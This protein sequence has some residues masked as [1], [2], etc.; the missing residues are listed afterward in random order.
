MTNILLYILIGIGVGYF[1]YLFCHKWPKL[2]KEDLTSI[3]FSLKSIQLLPKKIWASVI[4]TKDKLRHFSFKDLLRPLKKIRPSSIGDFFRRLKIK[5]FNQKGRFLKGLA[6]IKSC[7]KALLKETKDAQNFLKVRLGELKVGKRGLKLP[8]I[9]KNA[10]FSKGLGFQRKIQKIKGRTIKIFLEE[11]K[12]KIQVRF[13]SEEDR[14]IKKQLQAPKNTVVRPESYLGELLRKTEEA[15]LSPPAKKGLIEKQKE[16]VLITQ[17]ATRGIPDFLKETKPKRKA[18]SLEIS[19]ASIKKIEDRLMSEILEDP[20]NIEAYKKLGR[21]YYNQFKYHYAKECFEA[22]LKLGS[23]DKKI[24]R[25]LR[26]CGEK[27]RKKPA[28]SFH[29]RQV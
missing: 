8:E 16:D 4:K 9:S 20:K 18:P 27:L 6:L 22:A 12:H 28:P 2:Q 21:L 15:T 7:L 29:Q 23:G 1:V 10:L 26:R 14:E 11:L 19:Q 3:N 17:E 25:L 13:Q 5:I 24:K